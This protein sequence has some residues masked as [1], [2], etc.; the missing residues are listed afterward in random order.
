MSRHWA[1]SYSSA[2][3]ETSCSSGFVWASELE[4]VEYSVYTQNKAMTLL[5]LMHPSAKTDSAASFICRTPLRVAWGQEL[6]FIPAELPTE[7]NDPSELVG[8]LDVNQQTTLVPN[9]SAFSS[10]NMV[11]REES[12]SSVGSVLLTFT[13]FSFS[14]FPFWENHLE[15]LFSPSR[16]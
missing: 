12:T 3:E 6:L 13:S 16:N 8:T 1:S 14:L 2:A 7:S 10:H 11:L 5:S 4:G 15:D 9:S